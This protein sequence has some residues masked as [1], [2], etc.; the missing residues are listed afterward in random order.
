[1]TDP[2]T[3]H[4]TLPSLE[5]PVM[6]VMLTGWIDAS[7]AAAA[8]MATTVR[9]KKSGATRVLNRGAISTPAIPAKVLD[10]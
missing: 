1:M 9:L 8:A 3:L 6:V 5:Q 2:Y 4:Q 10:R 7:G